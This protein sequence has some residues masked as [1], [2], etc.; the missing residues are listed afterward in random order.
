MISIIVPVRNEA[1]CIRPL[2]E[3]LKALEGEKEIIVTDGG[4]TDGTV[5]L[6][7]SVAG[8]TVVLSEPGRGQQLRRGVAAAAG[9]VFWFVHAD[10]VVAAEAL[11]VI[12]EALGTDRPGTAG[13]GCFSL[14]FSDTDTPGLRWISR[15]S[16]SRARRLRLI[17]GDQGLFI[18]RR[19]Y[20]AVGGFRPIPIMEDW[21]L[22]RRLSRLGAPRVLETPIGTSG[23]RFIEEG[24]FRTLMRM[25][26]RK[27]RFTLGAS[28]ERLAKEYKEVRS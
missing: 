12:R 11:T 21:E 10:S 25:H 24:I 28:V 20:E 13:Y 26:W 9:E 4:S 19:T 5:E 2:L 27:L 8:V 23:R 7:Q 6:A 1:A 16:N 17:F 14:Y 22:S 3:A 18:T 15:T